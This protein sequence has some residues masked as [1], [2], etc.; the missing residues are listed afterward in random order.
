[1]PNKRPLLIVLFKLSQHQL[2]VFVSWLGKNDLQNHAST[3]LFLGSG[4]IRLQDEFFLLYYLK[5]RFLMS[6]P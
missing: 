5:Q 6:I 3:F 4:K 2:R 1:M